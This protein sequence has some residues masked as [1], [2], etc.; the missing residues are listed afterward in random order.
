MSVSLPSIRIGICGAENSAAP[1]TRQR[2]I[3]PVGYP[4]IVAA[5]GAEPVI[6]S[7]PSGR[8]HWGDILRDVHGVVYAGNNGGSAGTYADEQSLCL[9]CRDRKIPILAI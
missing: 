7:K 4:G 1:V 8:R 3:W 9:H 2:N 5:A 6:L